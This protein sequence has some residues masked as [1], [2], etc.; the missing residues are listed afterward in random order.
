LPT[1]AAT[2]AE[3]IQELMALTNVEGMMRQSVDLYK[4]NAAAN[5]KRSA[6]SPTEQAAAAEVL[7]GIGKIL[8]QRLGWAVMKPK[9]AALYD[10]SFSD[11][12]LDGMLAFYRSPAG[13]AMVAK[14]PQVM[15][16]GAQLGQQQMASAGPE[17]QQLIRN[18]MAK[19]Q[20]PAGKP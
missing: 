10:E 1:L 3:K 7:T 2:K 17:I 19:Q 11:A 12:E 14:M 13:K 5:I 6:A 16:K 18:A 9:F 15:A 20:K 4:A 8:D